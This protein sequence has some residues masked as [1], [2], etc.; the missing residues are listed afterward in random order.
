MDSSSQRRIT[1]KGMQFFRKCV[2][3]QL[4]SPDETL[5]TLGLTTEFNRLFINLG[6]YYLVNN[7]FPIYPKL[8]LELSCTIDIDLYNAHVESGKLITIGTL[9]FQMHN[10]DYELYVEALEGIL[11]LPTKGDGDVPKS[12]GATQFWGQI[13]WECPYMVRRAK[14]P[15]IQNPIFWYIHKVLAHTIFT[16]GDSKW[17]TILKEIYFLHPMI[18][19]YLVNSILFLSRW[20]SRYS[21]SKTREIMNG[22]LITTNIEHFGLIFN[23]VLDTPHLVRSWCDKE[24]LIQMGMIYH[25]GN[26]YDLI[27]HG[28]KKIYLPSRRRNKVDITSNLLYTRDD[29]I[30]EEYE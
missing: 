4:S 14:S 9:E 28:E 19:G 26:T 29:P 23:A 27:M 10:S 17:S 11:H 12:F 8:T 3:F 16:W 21:N 6:M 20:F 5:Y 7:Y 15:C 18:N 22:G 25:K 13:I 30:E 2:L 1:H 24:S